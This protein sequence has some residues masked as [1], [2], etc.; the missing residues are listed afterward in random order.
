M[1]VKIKVDGKEYGFKFT[2]ITVEK[3]G[4]RVGKE[5][6]EVFDYLAK[7]PFGALNNV[8]VVA[9]MVYNKGEAMDEYEMDELL[10]KMS[11]DQIRELRDAFRESLSKMIEKF[12]SLG[13]EESKK[14]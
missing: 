5:Y 10:E 8:F 4:K 14:N 6:H 13:K 2:M 3:L 11:E 9:N 7:E 12:A 1:E